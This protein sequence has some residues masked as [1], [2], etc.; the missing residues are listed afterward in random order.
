MI[1]SGDGLSLETDLDELSQ[2]SDSSAVE[3]VEDESITLSDSELEHIL[4]NSGP[5]LFDEGTPTVDAEPSLSDDALPELDLGDASEFSSG[6]SLEEAPP[7]EPFGL[8]DELSSE[9]PMMGEVHHD[10]DLS[11]TEP[12]EHDLG[13]ESDFAAHD[14]V[15][16]MMD[17]VDDEGPV[18]LSEDELGS[19]LSDVEEGPP[20]PLMGAEEP[21]D[22]AADLSHVGADESL[23]ASGDDF[24]E[25]EEEITLSD[26]E[27]ESVLLDM[28]APVESA[29]AHH[30]GAGGDRNARRSF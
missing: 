7:E 26:A 5:D 25:K 2:P 17:D 20:E 24:A 4:D 22:F 6:A 15:P 3:M 11:G 9:E 10:V 14:S 19:I 18:A 21:A 13:H 29:D 27:L 28:D 16:S 23:S 12:L 30:M 1:Y 8:P